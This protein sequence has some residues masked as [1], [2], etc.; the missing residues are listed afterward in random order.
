M[1][2]IRCPNIFIANSVREGDSSCPCCQLAC[3]TWPLEYVINFNNKGS[4]RRMKDMFGQR[5]LNTLDVCLTRD[6]LETIVKGRSGGEEMLCPERRLLHLLGNGRLHIIRS[7]DDGSLFHVVQFNQ[8]DADKLKEEVTKLNK[9]LSKEDVTKAIMNSF[10]INGGTIPPKSRCYIG[11]GSIQKLNKIGLYVLDRALVANNKNLPHIIKVLKIEGP[12]LQMKRDCLGLLS[13]ILRKEGV[14]ASQHVVNS[15]IVPLIITKY[16]NV[17]NVRTTSTVIDYIVETGPATVIDMMIELKVVPKLVQILVERIENQTE[18]FSL[19]I[20]HALARMAQR[21]TS[22]RD[23][24]LKADLVVPL[25]TLSE[26]KSAEISRDVAY[27]ICALCQGDPKPDFELVQSYLSVI[28]SILLVNDKKAVTRCG[29]TLL[30]LCESNDQRAIDST[31]KMVMELLGGT[32]DIAKFNAMVC[33]VLLMN[34]NEAVLE[35]LM[36]SD[37]LSIVVPLM[38]NSRL[39]FKSLALRI[40]C[41]ASK[42]YARQVVSQ[43]CIHIF[44]GL[45]ISSDHDIVKLSV[46]ALLRVSFVCLH[47]IPFLLKQP[48]TSFY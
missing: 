2:G 19:N 20:I 10:S 46:V 14:L 48:L 45:L 31:C 27:L 18:L 41:I 40:G 28:P 5:R 12:K 30:A 21:S 13:R 15:G 39:G 17:N 4:S 32:S 38:S 6:Q 36:D 16:L 7:D 42:K 43:G 29:K 34:G 8:K 1:L 44:F 11:R 9:Q 33:I 25:T 23:I 22:L 3:K 24:V 47:F 26:K 37:M 35:L